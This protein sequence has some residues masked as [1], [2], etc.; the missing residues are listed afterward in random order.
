MPIQ[1]AFKLKELNKLRSKND[2]IFLSKAI[3]PI[4]RKRNK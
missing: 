2:G 1:D 4:K 3:V